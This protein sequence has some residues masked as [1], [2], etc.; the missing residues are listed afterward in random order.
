MSDDWD[1][2]SL[3]VDSEPASIMVDLGIRHSVPIRTHGYM[4]YLRTHMNN[5]RP[6]GLSSQEEFNQLCEIGDAIDAVIDGSKGNHFY[7]GRNTSSGNRDFY[8]YTQNQKHLE[9]SLSEVINAF[10]SY[11]FE[12]SGKEDTKWDVYTDF[13]YPKPMD[14]QRIMNRRV[15]D[16]LEKKG[17][18][19]T[20]PRE[21]DHRVYFSKKQVLKSYQDF[22]EKLNFTITGTGRTKPLV[23]EYYIDF[24][25]VDV[26]AEIDETVYEIFTKSTELN[27]TYDGWGCTVQKSETFTNA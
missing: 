2:Y 22:L 8:F 23:G 18:V 5:P 16:H 21:I 6:D 7:V 17:D 26:P 4:G 3:L 1:F 25:R 11:E 9:E 12:Q 14:R 13:L 10:P 24:K 20:I 27:G 15:C 19:L